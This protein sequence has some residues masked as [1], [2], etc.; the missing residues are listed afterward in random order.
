M[1]TANFV[2][3]AGARQLLQRDEVDRVMPLVERDHPI[4]DAAMRVAIEVAAVDDLGR[5]IERVVVNQDCA[6]HRL[7]GFE[8]VRKRVLRC[9]NGSVGHERAYRL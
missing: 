5:Q 6:E 7:L 4:E 9:G 8:V 3:L 2:Q 1:R